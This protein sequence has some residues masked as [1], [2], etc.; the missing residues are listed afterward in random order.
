MGLLKVPGQ[1]SKVTFPS[2]GHITSFMLG[3]WEETCHSGFSRAEGPLN[4]PKGDVRPAP[5]HTSAHV[6]AWGRGHDLLVKGGG[7]SPHA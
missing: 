7:S 6:Q 2:N 1:G 4:C 5:G 3:P